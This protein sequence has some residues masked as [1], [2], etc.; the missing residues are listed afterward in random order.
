MNKI[1]LENR[2]GNTYYLEPTEINGE[3]KFVGNTDFIRVGYYGPNK[4]IIEFIDPSGGPFISTSSEIQCRKIIKI[5]NR[6]EGFI[7]TLYPGQDT[8]IIKVFDF[9]LKRKSYNRNYEMTGCSRLAKLKKGS[10]HECKYLESPTVKIKPGMVINNK[11]VKS[12][13][14]FPCGNNEYSYEIKFEE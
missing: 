2:Y 3:Y 5:E 7:L 14:C 9:Y 12:L 13:W 11:K 4:D 6:Q 8:E 1:K 10:L